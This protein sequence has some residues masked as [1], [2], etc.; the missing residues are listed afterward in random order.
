MESENFHFIVFQ[1]E[2]LRLFHYLR[3]H[4]YNFRKLASFN[5]ERNGNDNLSV[6]HFQQN[7][8]RKGISEEWERATTVEK[9]N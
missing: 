5:L 6:F 9:Y 7:F 3:K 2:I 8:Y 1:W 4:S